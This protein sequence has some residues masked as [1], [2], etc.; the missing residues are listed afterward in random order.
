[1]VRRE[2][3]REAVA[4]SLVP[5][6]LILSFR[7]DGGGT[8]WSELQARSRLPTTSQRLCRLV[9][10]AGAARHVALQVLPSA[11]E[12]ENEKLKSSDPSPFALARAALNFQL[13]PLD[14]LTS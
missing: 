9:S 14:I 2:E 8:I 3:T 6:S 7:G 12:S 10:C 5:A 1:M 13:P 4:D 11:L